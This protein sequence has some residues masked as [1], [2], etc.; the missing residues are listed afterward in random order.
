MSEKVQVL[1]IKIYFL[2]IEA[3]PK[4]TGLLVS[5]GHF[6]HRILENSTAGH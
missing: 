1:A 3:C 5:M 6:A 2:E 4:A